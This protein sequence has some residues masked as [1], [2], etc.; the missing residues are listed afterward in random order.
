MCQTQP[1]KSSNLMGKFLIWHVKF[2]LKMFPMGF[3]INLIGLIL[4]HCERF[5]RKDL[6]MP[7]LGECDEWR[8][9]GFSILMEV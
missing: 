1:K 5:L 9:T 2:G 7:A 8:V 6:E 4:L 3:F